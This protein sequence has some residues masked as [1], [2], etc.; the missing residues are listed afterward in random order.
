MRHAA[1]DRFGLSVLGVSVERDATGVQVDVKGDL[2][3]L[4]YPMEVNLVGDSAE[5]LRAMLVQSNRNRLFL[6]L[7]CFIS[8]LT[9]FETISFEVLA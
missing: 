5:T 2:L 8:V 6:R 4:R 7:P 3:S 9:F 1:H